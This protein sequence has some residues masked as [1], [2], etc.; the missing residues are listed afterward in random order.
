[1]FPG[2]KE[3]TVDVQNKQVIARGDVKL[4]TANHRYLMMK[5]KK[6]KFKMKKK[7]LIINFFRTAWICN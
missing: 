2:L 7:H 4:Y 6:I 3:Y 5:K 1:M